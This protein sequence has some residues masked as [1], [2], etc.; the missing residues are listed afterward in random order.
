MNACIDL[1]CLPNC[2]AGTLFSAIDVLHAANKLWHLRHPRSKTPP[3]SWRLL[4]SD[5]EELPLPAWLPA[6]PA[7]PQAALSALLVPGLDMDSVP[8]LKQLLDQSGKAQ[9]M[10]ARRHAAGDVIATNYNGAALL[11]RAG[12]LDGRNATISWMIA[13][14]F[15]SSHPRVHLLMDRPVTQDH[16]IYCSGAPASSTELLLELVRHFAGDELAQRCTNGLLYLPA[17]FEQSAQTL[18]ALST[19]T[20]DS[21]VFKARRWLEQH[22]A[23][24]YSLDLAAAAAAVS[25]R[26]LLRHFREVADMTPLDYLHKLRVERAKLLLEVTTLDLAGIMEQCGYDDPSAFRRLFRRQTGLTPTAYR[27]AYALRASRQRWRAHDSIPQQ[28]EARQSG[29][30]CA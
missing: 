8:Q 25:S 2:L 28:P 18:P 13:G 23:E 15:S 1:L 30:A 24:P 12:I 29:A 5:G 16:G 3:F 20:R 6:S 11:A 27:R 26:T 10:I 22:V 4:D 17:R 7:R 21:V 14:W 19:P 9:Q